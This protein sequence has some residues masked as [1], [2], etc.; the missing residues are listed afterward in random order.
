MGFKVRYVLKL[1]FFLLEDILRK[2][3]LF[4]LQV[5]GISLHHTFSKILFISGFILLL[6]F[7]HLQYFENKTEPNHNPFEV[8]ACPC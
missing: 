7:G 3:F 6:P 8:S 4:E 5:D 1:F 2:P